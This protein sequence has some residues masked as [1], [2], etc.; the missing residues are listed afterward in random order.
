MATVTAAVEKKFVGYLPNDAPPLGAMIGL[1]FQH[2]LTMFPATVLVAILTGFDV[3]VTLFA[4]GLATIAALLLSS[5]LAKSYIPL[6]YGSSFSYIAPI[7]AITTTNVLNIDDPI[8]R[9]RVA[10]GGI[11]MTGVINILVGILIRYVGKDALD[12]ILPPEV[13]GSVATVIGIALAFTALQQASGTITLT[14]AAGAPISAGS[15]WIVSLVTLIST[16]IF[17]VYLRGKGFMGMI[18]VLLGGI[19]GYIV[20]LF[21]K[22]PEG[23][24]MFGSPIGGASMVNFQPVLDASWLR[25]P[26]F[27]LPVFTFAAVM[28][29]APIAI[30]TIPESTAHLYQIS[31][32]VDQLAVQLG[33]KPIKL[34][35]FLGLNL[36]CDGVGDC[37]NGMLGGCPGTNYGENNSL[38][39]ITRNYSGPVLIAAGVIAMLLGF[40]GK[41]AELVNTLPTAVTGGLAIYLFG[42]IGAQGIAL[43]I[44]KRVNMFD[45]RKLAI[46]AVILVVGIGG[47]I[48]F[49]G[50]MIPFFGLQ[51]PAIA[52][53]AVVG[54]LLNLVFMFF[55]AKQIDKEFDEIKIEELKIDV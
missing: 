2:V 31:L 7:V 34:S 18:P 51:L 8:M 20:A 45:P 53:S 17:S 49:T 46:I 35:R 40:V 27:T 33:K 15:W 23:A 50:G 41:L 43:Q 37:I 13:T 1:A 48:G 10:Q 39:A 9:I 5:R 24:Y 28:A 32:Y 30:A 52:T 47:S 55:P 11:M 44:A 19:V 16:I 25:L 14:D 29:I 38:M 12:K 3:G 26:A 54:I 42:V 21:M 36:V 4:S 22:H 6:Y